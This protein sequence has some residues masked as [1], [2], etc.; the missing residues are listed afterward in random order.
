VV[1]GSTR[2]RLKPDLVTV[3]GP[4]TVRTRAL[5]PPTCNAWPLS[6]A[7]FRLFPFRSPLLGESRLI[8]FPRGTEM[9]QFPRLPS[10]AYVFSTERRRITGA[11]L[12]HSEIRGSMPVQRLTAAY[13]SRPRPSSAPG[14]KA[15][16]VC[17]YYLDGEF[18]HAEAHASEYPFTFLGLGAVFKL[19]RDRLTRDSRPRS[20]KTEQ[21]LPPARGPTT[22]GPVDIQRD[23]SFPARKRPKRARPASEGSP[24]LCLPRKEVIQPQLP[25]RLP[26]YDFT[27]ITSP[28][29]D[30]SLP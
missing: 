15:S 20:L 8:S 25:L 17:P 24:V 13:R 28:T 19:R 1:R 5:R 10:S 26:C 4:A 30:G 9:C 6:H 22:Q 3:A 18:A 29:F 2:L 16:T 23:S 12:P 11:G 21:R 7:G 27:P 14:A